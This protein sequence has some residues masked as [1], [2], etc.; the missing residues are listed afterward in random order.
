MGVGHVQEVPAGTNNGDVLNAKSNKKE[1]SVW[2]C[3]LEM[4]GLEKCKK[5]VMRMWIVSKKCHWVETM[6]ESSLMQNQMKME[7]SG[8]IC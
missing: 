3:P 5:V 8:W 7:K 6:R 1:K 2:I 4:V